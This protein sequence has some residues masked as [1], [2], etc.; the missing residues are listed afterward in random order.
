MR[1]FFEYLNKLKLE[2][3][4]KFIEQELIK[5]YIATQQ[6]TVFLIDVNGAA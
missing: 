5:H 2:F 3:S 1:F 6:I 4:K